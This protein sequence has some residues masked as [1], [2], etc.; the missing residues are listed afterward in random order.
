MPHV[1]GNLDLLIGEEQRVN[2]KA[3][4]FIVWFVAIQAEQ[5]PFT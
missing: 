4:S 5:Y 3:F 2:G 1:K